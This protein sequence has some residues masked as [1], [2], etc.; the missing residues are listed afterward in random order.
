[1][2]LQIFTDLDERYSRDQI[3]SQHKN[4]DVDQN[5]SAD[6]QALYEFPEPIY[7]AG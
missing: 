2:D 6:C 4:M 7:Y 5:A 1:M 3:S